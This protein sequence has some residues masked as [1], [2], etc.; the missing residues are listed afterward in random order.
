MGWIWTGY[1]PILNRSKRII[2]AFPKHMIFIIVN[3]GGTEI[4]GKSRM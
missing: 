4:F 3:V 2:K 1:G